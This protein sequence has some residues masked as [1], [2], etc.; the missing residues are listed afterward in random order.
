MGVEPKVRGD[1]KLFESPF[2]IRPPDLVAA[3][4]NENVLGADRL[5]VFLAH[6]GAAEEIDDPSGP[7]LEFE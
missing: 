2:R 4:D 5:V 1:G 6:L 7:A 3:H